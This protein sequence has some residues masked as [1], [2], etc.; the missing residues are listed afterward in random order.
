MDSSVPPK[1]NI[2]KFFRLG[3]CKQGKDCPFAHP[4]TDHVEPA[5]AEPVHHGTGQTRRKGGSE[6]KVI[7]KFFRQGKCKDGEACSFL[8]LDQ[9]EHQP[10][11]PPRLGADGL[12]DSERV[13]KYFLTGNCKFGLGCKNLHVRKEDSPY[14]QDIKLI[15]ADCSS[16]FLSRYTQKQSVHLVEFTTALPV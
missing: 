15:C 6:R 7:C 8:H 2:C 12:K 11:E 16:E 13:C 10:A 3:K 1:R 4:G 9:I 5:P 14:V